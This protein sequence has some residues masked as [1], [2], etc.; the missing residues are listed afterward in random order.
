MLK[1]YLVCKNCG[2]EDW[3]TTPTVR[4]EHC[5]AN[6]YDYASAC[7]ACGKPALRDHLTCGAPSC[8]AKA[9]RAL[10]QEAR[11]GLSTDYADGLI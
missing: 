8:N 10:Q 5:G 2:A 1:V 3:H 11:D 4:C 6:D 9:L 7:V